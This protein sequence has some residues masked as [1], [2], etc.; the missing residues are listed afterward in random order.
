ML[1]VAHDVMS[2]RVV[3]G[4]AAE[5]N[6]AGTDARE[7]WAAG[8]YTLPQDVASVVSTLQGLIFSGPDPFLAS[9]LPISLSGERIL[10]SE[11]SGVVSSCF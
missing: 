8:Y 7:P 10:N 9:F 4:Q 6:G 2:S 1:G 3:P 11:Y 5:I